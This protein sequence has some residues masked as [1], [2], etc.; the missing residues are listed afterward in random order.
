MAAVVQ[1]FAAKKA[2]I[3]VG[4]TL[5]ITS[6]AL[7]VSQLA[8]ATMASASGCGY[9]ASGCKPPGHHKHHKRHGHRGGHGSHSGHGSGHHHQLVVHGVH[10]AV[11][12]LAH[13]GH[14][15]H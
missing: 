15:L 7:A 4:A 12:V 6:V 5:G 10:A 11:H 2:G 14:G 3:R 8:M 1:K 13:G 9:G